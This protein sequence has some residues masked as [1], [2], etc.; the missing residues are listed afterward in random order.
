M[1]MHLKLKC[2]LLL[3]L[4]SFSAQPQ[5]MPAD[6]V[7]GAQENPADTVIVPLAETSKIIFTIGNPDDLEI[8]RHYDFQALFDDILEKLEKR[9][10]SEKDSADQTASEK[11]EDWGIT[12]SEEN[13]NDEPEYNHDDEDDDHDEFDWEKSRRGKIG[14]T[15]QSQ[16]IDL[17]MN[18]YLEGDQFPD[19]GEPY[20]VRP[21]G[22]WYVAWNSVQRTRLGKN[23]FAEWALG[24]NWYSFK[25][26]ED[27]IL[28]EKGEE[29]I[30][31]VRDSRDVHFIKSKLSATYI[32]ASLIPVLD[33]G[34]HSRRRR[35]WDSHSDGGFRFGIGP[36]V[37]YRISSKSKLVYEEDDGDR[38]KEKNHDNLYL[39][40]LR[41]GFR[42]QWG[43]GSTD[44]FVNYDMNELFEKDK[45]PK[46]NAISFGLIF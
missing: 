23:F 3:T 34:N 24:V 11:E 6:T 36:Y 37:G 46:L 20:A 9:T 42:L 22:S 10:Q 39:N 21:W 40:N 18:N 13:E 29:G 7:S 8:L 44:L 32:N 16:N 41:Y 26:Q 27:N 14:Q 4:L 35:M 30:T 5:E 25:F 17:G 31:F 1:S 38:E 45:G 19:G 28:I 15:W 43:V 2:A 33:F 12:S